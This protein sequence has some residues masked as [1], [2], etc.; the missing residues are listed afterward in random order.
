MYNVK[1]HQNFESDEI[2]YNKILKMTPNNSGVWKNI[3]VVNSEDYDFFVI[4]N[5]PTHNNFD[6]KKT[7]IFECE[8]KTTRQRFSKYYKNKENEFRYVHTIE[9]HHSVDIWYHG[10]SYDDLVKPITKT[11]NFSVVNSGLNSLPGHI[12]RNNFITY[13]EDKMEYDLYGRFYSNNKNYKHPLNNKS[14][15]LLDYKYTYNCENDFENNYFTE[16]ILDGIMCE[17]VTFYHACPNIEKFINP[18]S[19]VILDFDIIK[20]YETIKHSIE[21]NKFEY[22]ISNIK[23]EKKRIIND[24]NLMNIVNTVIGDV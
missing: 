2:L 21:D 16:K 7:L 3:K 19:F 10:L 20:S 13:I 4:L 8:T 17:C 22:M 24:Y 18:N 5:H 15:G 1:F 14:D 9:K 6:K 11:K 23:E 12:L